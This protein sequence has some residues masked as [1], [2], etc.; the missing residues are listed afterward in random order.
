MPNITVFSSHKWIS[1]TKYKSRVDIDP[2][3]QGFSTIYECLKL[4]RNGDKFYSKL[5][6][7]EVL[8]RL[9]PLS[10]E[11]VDYGILSRSKDVW[12]LHKRSTNQLKQCNTCP[13]NVIVKSKR[14]GNQVAIKA[15]WK[16]D[17]LQRLVQ[18]T[19]K[20]HSRILNLLEMY[21]YEVNCFSCSGDTITWTMRKY[22]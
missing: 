17:D 1:L 2:E 18:E 19:K 11:T 8:D 16:A 15:D 5:P 22:A 21:G 7:N 20:G 14:K 12:S 6:T 3:S 4:V 10:Y 13:A 9:S